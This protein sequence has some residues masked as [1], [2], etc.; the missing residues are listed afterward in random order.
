MILLSSSTFFLIITILIIHFVYGQPTASNFQSIQVAAQLA[1][2][3][4]SDAGKK[5]KSKQNTCVA[6]VFI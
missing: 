3:V 6:L 4:V 2:K 5:K 1:R